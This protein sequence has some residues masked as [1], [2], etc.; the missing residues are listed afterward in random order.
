MRYTKGNVNKNIKK[1]DEE[2]DLSELD[3]FDRTLKLKQQNQKKFITN[4]R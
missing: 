3:A 4:S 1:T 2:A